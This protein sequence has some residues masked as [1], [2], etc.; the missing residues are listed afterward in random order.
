VE[1][2]KQ[3]RELG[4]V[5]R[6]GEGGNRAANVGI[7]LRAMEGGRVSFYFYLR[8]FALSPCPHKRMETVKV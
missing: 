3:G 1:H 5:G 4:N 7:S 8:P 6:S 2:P